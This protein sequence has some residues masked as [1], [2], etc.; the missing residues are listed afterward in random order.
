M[1][2]HPRNEEVESLLKPDSRARLPFR[3]LLLLYLHPFALFKDASRGPASVRERALTYNRAM[4]WMLIA[5][6]RRWAAIA[7]SLFLAIDPAQALAAGTS[8]AVIPA[9]LLAVGCCIALVVIVCTGTSYL[10]LG[11][12]A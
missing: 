8:L 7:T 5:Y 9:A 11:R 12:Q 1:L 4:R 6:L 3:R 2:W 10:M